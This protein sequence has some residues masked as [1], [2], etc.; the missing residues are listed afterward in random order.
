MWRDL[1]A[2]HRRAVLIILIASVLLIGG[3]AVLV[4]RHRPAD[5]A[6]PPQGFP[7]TEEQAPPGTEF[8][9]AA[10]GGAD[11]G[12]SAGSLPDSGSVPTAAG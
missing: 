9:P 3:G 4:F 10:V 1:W 12:G 8:A 6:V 11:A 5:E 2:T 7:A